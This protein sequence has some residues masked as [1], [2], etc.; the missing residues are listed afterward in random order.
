MEDVINY[1]LKFFFPPSTHILYHW[2]FEVLSTKESILF[3]P[4]TLGSAM[5]LVLVCGMLVGRCDKCMGLNYACL[6]GLTLLYMLPLWKVFPRVAATLLPGLLH[7]YLWS[8]IALPAHRPVMWAEWLQ[9]LAP[10]VALTD[11]LT[12]ERIKSLL[13]LHVTE[14]LWLFLYIS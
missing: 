3:H 2:N 11:F 5:G 7:I 13:L 9:P 1:W 10:K 12:H 8:R 4:L 14:K 6:K